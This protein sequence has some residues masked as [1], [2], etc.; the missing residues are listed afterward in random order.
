[1][2]LEAVLLAPKL[3]ASALYYKTKL[4]SHNFTIYD[5]ATNDVAVY[6]WNESEGDLSASS[7]V[8]CVTHFITTLPL[9]VTELIL[10]SDGCTYQ[11]RNAILANALIS[12]AKSRGITI[13]QK[14]LTKGHTQMECDS[15]HSTLE[16]LVRNKPVYSPYSYVDALKS[17]RP[18]QPYNVQYITHDFF[19]DFTHLRHYTSIRPGTQTG[20]PVVT[21]VV[22]YQYRPDGTAFYKLDFGDA[23]KALP[24]RVTRRSNPGDMDN[25]DVGWPRLHKGPLPIKGSKFKHLQELKAVIPMDFHAFYDNLPHGNV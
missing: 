15:V 8:S 18:K 14:Y 22:C 7:F 13:T 23:F 16:Q 2:D 20:D 4:A 24:K 9:N 19:H 5:L 1:M 21:N 17:A 25:H 6:F 3:N 11:N 10:Y 12:V